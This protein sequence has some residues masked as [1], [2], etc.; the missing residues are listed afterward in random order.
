MAI[1]ANAQ[2]Y[3]FDKT[4]LYHLTKIT[5]GKNLGRG[6]DETN[7]KPAAAAIESSPVEHSRSRPSA[8]GYLSR[9][10]YTN[11]SPSAPTS[12][13]N[14]IHQAPYRWADPP[15]RHASIYIS[16]RTA[17]SSFQSVSYERHESTNSCDQVDYPIVV[18]VVRVVEIAPI[19]LKRRRVTVA[20]QTPSNSDIRGY[21]SS[22]RWDHASS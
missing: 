15:N 14:Y 19:Q 16:S 5:I 3:R 7:S 11:L 10:T 1:T 12:P 21:L 22:E 18:L 13:T 6:W 4:Y 17:R 2:G 9:C 20:K 8:H